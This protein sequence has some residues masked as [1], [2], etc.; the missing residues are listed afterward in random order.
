[1]SHAFEPT[2]RT[3]LKAAAAAAVG[4]AAAGIAAYTP[5]AQ[6]ATDRTV[7]ST[8]D[9]ETDVV[10]IGFGVAGTGA[11]TAAADAGAEV[12]L[13][14]KAPK[15]E[16]GGSARVNGGYM[17]IRTDFWDPQVCYRHLKG[18]YDEDLMKARLEAWPLMAEWIEANP[19]DGLVEVAGATY[20][21]YFEPAGSWKAYPSYVAAVESRAAI[22]VLYDTPAIDFVQDPQSHEILGVWAVQNGT[23][24]AVKA[25]M[26][27]VLASGS[28]CANAEL[29]RE[30]NYPGMFIATLDSPYNTGDGIF[31]GARAGAQ[32]GGFFPES[33]EYEQFALKVPSEEIG[34]GIMYTKPSESQASQ[35]FVN[36]AGK[37]FMNEM[38]NIT[39][40]RNRLP[41]FDWDE[42]VNDYANSP[43]WMVFDQQFMDTV[44]VGCYGTE[45]T[46][47][48][49]IMTW[50]GVFEKYLWSEDNQAELDRGWIVT[51][52]TLE[53]LAARME[54]TTGLG[55]QVSVDA[56]GLA[57]AVADYNAGCAAGEDAFGR[58]P[59]FLNPL[60]DGPYYAIEL[61]VAPMYGYGGPQV[62][63]ENQVV[64]TDGNA[65]GRLYAAGQVSLTFSPTSC[66]PTALT[67]G[68]QAGRSAAAL[69]SWQ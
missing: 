57:Q 30:F 62:N 6:A 13:L 68:I 1:M 11:A 36:R 45:R 23:P 20:E 18:V 53:E 28:Y 69:D 14:E 40:T 26:G 51:G 60:G 64:D 58:A 15:E 63:T 19:V 56:A 44:R 34:T 55:D 47:D 31:M 54:A 48:D 22:E 24:V 2:R 16:A 39:H 43:F 61:C 41:I 49:W 4:T 32:L 52:A 17:T 33:L 37:R 38:F 8:W 35:I 46:E 10:V 67:A 21:G 65:L 50:N 59:E 25:R 5:L 7:P 3:L 42:T 66:V 9:Y 27:V 12:I 29:I